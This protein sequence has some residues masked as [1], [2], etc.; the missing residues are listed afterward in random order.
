MKIKSIAVFLTMAVMVLF[1][2]CSQNGNEN[3]QS[4]TENT[5]ATVRQ[6]ETDGNFTADVNVTAEITAET[7]DTVT[8]IPETSAQEEVPSVTEARGSV[9]DSY[10]EDGESGIKI[11][12]RNGHYM[13]LMCCQGT[14]ENCERYADAVNRAADE[15]SDINVYS[16]VIPTSSEFYVPDDIT[17]FTS[18][19]KEKIDYILERLTGAVNVDVYSVLSEHTDEHIYSRTDHHWQPLGAYY[20]AKS[21][22][23]TAGVSDKFAP[24]SEY[25]LV[26]REGYMGSLY[27]YS[28]SAQLKSDPEPFTMYIPPNDSALKT[29]YY[30]FDLE[31]GHD[32]DLFASRDGSAYYISF[33]SVKYPTAKIETDCTNGKTLVIMKES[34]GNALVPFLTECY[35]TI[36]VCD[37]R[38]FEW[39]LTDFCRDVGADDLLFATCTYT[40]AG[41]GVA[42]VEKVIG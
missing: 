9:P 28:E 40:P 20:A 7:V 10:R 31:E 36:Y 3:V 6:T 37:I 14:F 19:Q 42:F 39:K 1:A 33:L 5:K 23:K 4:F 12:G 38:A 16:M 17:N 8:D 15:L 35:H 30:D 34:Y 18:S 41:E 32:G 24:L 26:T 13:G 21:F 29:T 22:A 27:N 2:G 11:I 25:T